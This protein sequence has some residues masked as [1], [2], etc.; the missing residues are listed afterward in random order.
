MNSR[1]LRRTALALVMAA[2]GASLY[3][4]QLEQIRASGVITLAHRE[5]SIPFSFL[6]A[7]KHAVGYSI[8]LCLKLVQAIRQELNLPTLQVKYLAVTSATRLTAIAQ[9]QAA[10]ECGST[11]NTAERRQQVDYTIAHFISAARFLVRSG[12][13]LTSLASLAGKTV[14]ST[15]GTTNLKTLE[16]LNVEYALGMK[17]V[18]A[19][20]HAQAFSL[21]TTGKVDAF[22][23]DDVLLYGLRANADK[24]EAFE[25]MGKAM[26]VE[27]Y[28]IVLP[29][30]D[31]ALKA[32]VDKEMRRIIQS[33]EIYP[34]YQKWFQAPIPP[35][36]INLQ[37]PMPYML[38]DSFKFPSDKVGDFAVDTASKQKK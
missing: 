30:G 21:V 15:Q 24:P 6:D 32:L 16:R 36:G 11:T 26:T 7:D 9:G 13:G 8:D 12:S 34:I 23:M 38:R 31:A 5:A 4:G 37:L 18:T 10:M 22:A 28:A 17:L 2:H 3:A 33:G 14:V 27:P 19:P 1:F 20:D 29:K 35:R 25:V